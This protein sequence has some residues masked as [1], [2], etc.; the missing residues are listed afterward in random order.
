MYPL[1]Y[2]E[3]IVAEDLD[4]G[5]KIIATNKINSFQVQVHMRP[6]KNLLVN[7]NKDRHLDDLKECKRQV[8]IL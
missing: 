5:L 6:N 7:P 2:L 8:Q 3:K 1:Y 4:L